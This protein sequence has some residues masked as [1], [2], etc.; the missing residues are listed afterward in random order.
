MGG[1]AFTVRVGNKTKINLMP[2]VGV[3]AHQQGNL[4]I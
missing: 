2:A 1:K 3:I 4:N